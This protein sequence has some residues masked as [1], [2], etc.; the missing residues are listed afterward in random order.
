MN[1][2]RS[3]TDV[4]KSNLSHIISYKLQDIPENMYLNLDKSFL[5]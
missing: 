2:I 1:Y 5:P 3:F 4:K